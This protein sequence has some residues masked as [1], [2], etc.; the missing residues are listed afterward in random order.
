MSATPSGTAGGAG[1]VLAVGGVYVGQSLLGGL[2][3][4]A[5]PGIL[6][7]RGLPLDLVG[8]VSLVSLPWALKILWSQGVERYRLPPTGSARSRRIVAVCGLATLAGLAAAAFVD[9][10]NWPLLL[11][12]FV[13]I[14]FAAST[15]DI[16]ADGH[17]VESLAAS[18]HGWA[19]AAQVG[20]AYLGSALGSGL[21]LIL[22]ARLD[23]RAAVLLTAALFAVLLLPFLL[24][25]PPPSGP[26]EHQPSLRFALGRP[27]LRAGLLLAALYV[28]SM[29]WGVALS[30]PFLVDA[31]LDLAALGLVNGLGGLG[32]GFASALA[33]GALVRL[34]GA[35]R[36]M[37]MALALQGAVL[38]ALAFCAWHGGSP[39]AM[40]VGLALAGS[41]GVMALGFVALYAAFMALADPRQAGI[42]FTLLQGVDALVSMAGGLGAGVTAQHLGY[43]G[44][45]GMA[46]FLVMAALPALWR[47]SRTAN[48]ASCAKT[49]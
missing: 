2:V 28:V 45:F 47:L 18:H 21:F 23:W 44:Y 17:A 36:V 48:L 3:F 12:L 43:G 19:N 6:R 49:P 1:T 27:R 39:R 13:A 24:V 33:G 42:D 26:R 10:A 20:G 41:S 8:L 38:A 46:S 37:L 29:K 35:A 7:E 32:V 40:L 11:G 14:A 31:G 25:R 5:L 30:G 9:L 22:V 15:A 34:W 16:A 4:I